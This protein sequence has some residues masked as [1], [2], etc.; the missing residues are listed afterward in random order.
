MALSA[1]AFMNVFDLPVIFTDE[2]APEPLPRKFFLASYTHVIFVKRRHLKHLEYFSS[3]P[4]LDEKFSAC[5][6]GFTVSHFFQ[7]DFCQSEID[8]KLA[9]VYA[10]FFALDLISAAEQRT[11]EIYGP[12]VLSRMKHENHFGALRRYADQLQLQPIG[13]RACQRFQREG[14]FFSCS[15][16]RTC[17]SL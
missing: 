9:F 2:D 12:I 7:R 11:M 10:N 3:M 5:F 17:T 8:L 15:E 16:H 4:D 14:I 6:P 13:I 1:F